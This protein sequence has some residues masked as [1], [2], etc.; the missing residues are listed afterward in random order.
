MKKNLDNYFLGQPKPLFSLSLVELWERFSYYG[1]RP[2]LV[3]YM[4]ALI[5]NGGLE[6]D[7]KTAAAIVG[8]Y[9]G[10]VYLMPLFGGFL[11]DNWLGQKRATFYGA[12]IIALGHLC[13]GL[14]GIFDVSF[15][16]IGLIFIASG[17]GLFKT[18]SSVMVG[19]LYSDTDRR[20]D[21][22][23]I[24]FYMCIN[25]GAFLAPL[26]TGFFHQK[27]GWALGFGVGGVGML[28]SLAIF[29][30]KTLRDFDE[31]RLQHNLD[32][33]YDSPKVRRKIAPFLAAAYVFIMATIIILQRLDFIKIDP[34][35][36]SRIMVQIIGGFF[37]LYFVVLFLI[38]KGSRKNIVVLFLLIL[39]AAVFWSSADQQGIGFN[40]FADKYTNR[41]F[42]GFTIPTVWFQSINPLIIILFAVPISYL[43]IVLSRR[44]LHVSS[45]AKF[46]LGLIL[47]GVGY[48]IIVVAT[49]VVLGGVSLVS[50]LW[51]LFSLLF[52][53]IGELFVS[54]VGLSLMTQISPKSIK[55]QVMGLWF[56]ASSVGVLVA[57][58]IGG[59]VNDNDLKSLPELY[60]DVT[61][62]LFIT[63]GLLFLAVFLLRRKK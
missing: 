27:Y 35:F 10:M 25:I 48:I 18:C 34:I 52:I 8:V 26:L 38:E 44:G 29:Y 58:L 40:L 51:L 13:I 39:A 41:D 21:S 60:T 59:N 5:V 4:S 55:N 7:T 46:S 16:F 28:I 53:T 33:T 42:L 54:P 45:V 30:F 57:G 49:K 56:L 43:W 19:M 2:L 62:T 15:L 32:A 37:V 23:F 12:I 36:L 47:T 1:I 22:G 14:S 61:Y 31:Y 63:A 11:A 9:G 20:R 24:I 3:L 50:P 6:F 17:T